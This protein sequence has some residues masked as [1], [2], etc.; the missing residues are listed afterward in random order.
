MFV[1]FAH[2]LHFTK[3]GR[4]SAAIGLSHPAASGRRSVCSVSR[5]SFVASSPPM[6]RWNHD[7]RF[8]E[9]L[10]T[11]LQAFE[12]SSPNA[13]NLTCH[14]ARIWLWRFFS[15]DHVGQRTGDLG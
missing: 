15:A 4:S 5:R 9:N 13:C 11:K 12:S 14:G 3:M 8:E 7:L 1:H 2:R 10:K 6:P